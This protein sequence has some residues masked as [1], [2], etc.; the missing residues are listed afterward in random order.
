MTWLFM[1]V[2]SALFAGLTSILAKCGIRKTDSD[3]ATALRTIVVLLFSW[4]MVFV[5]G[6]LPTITSISTKSLI[7]LILS[8]FATGASWICYFKALAM[9]DVN[10][11]VPIDKSSTILTVLLAIICFG[12]TDNLPVKLS[13]TVLLAV[14]IFLMI[15]KKKAAAHEEKRIWMIYAVLAAVFAALTSILA[16]MGIS[17]VESN[18][19]T[20]IRTCVVLIM[21][22][23]VV[24]SQGKQKQL[25]SLDKKELLFIALSGVA[26]GA[27]WLCYYYAIQKGIVSVVV[28]IDKLSI[29]V[30]IVFS[31]FVFKERLSKKALLGLLLMVVGTLI[32]A[33]G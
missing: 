16:K 13:G 25:A 27:S 1:A 3:V 14:G 7:F 29:I 10:K 31:Y 2:L 5:V 20:A 12:E 21:A 26:T 19:G 23:V 28:P 4:I 30:S 24:F 6:S 33:I 32:M 9:G 8:G 17:G 18:L 22:W 11:V 15:E